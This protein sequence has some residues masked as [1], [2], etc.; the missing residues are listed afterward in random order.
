MEKIKSSNGNVVSLKD[1]ERELASRGIS[2]VKV[3]VSGLSQWVGIHTVLNFYKKGD[4][5]FTCD[6]IEEII[7]EM[8]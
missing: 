5:E 6:T 2:V 3:H 1:L 7:N 8:K 4:V